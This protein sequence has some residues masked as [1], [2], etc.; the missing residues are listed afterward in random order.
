MVYLKATLVGIVTATALVTYG[1]RPSSL[2]AQVLAG[3]SFAVASVKPNHSDDG[4]AMLGSQSGDRFTATNAPLRGLIRQAYQ[5]QDDQIIGG[6]AWI[7][8]SRFDVL[9]KADSTLPRSMPGV[10][11]PAQLMLQRL[12]ADRFKLRTHAGRRE[13]SI[14]ALLLVRRDG[15]LGPQLHHAAFDCTSTAPRPAGYSCGV[16]VNSTGTMVGGDFP[17]SQLTRMLSNQLRRVV[18]DRTGL[19]G[20]FDGTLTWTPDER[21]ANLPSVVSTNI[22]PAGPSLFAALRDQFGLRLQ[23]E[24]GPVDVLVIDS[25]G[26]LIP[27]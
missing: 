24:R 4:I 18:V 6:P 1:T 25:V 7:S 14:Y 3:P 9:A 12:L 26:Q 13:L 15:G 19:D 23:A 5:L 2:H 8:T 17:L 27:D 16:R 21:A 22:D 10:I 11:G 20:R